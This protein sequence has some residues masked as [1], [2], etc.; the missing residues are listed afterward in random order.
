MVGRLEGTVA[1]EEVSYNCSY[2]VTIAAARVYA[3]TGAINCG[4]CSQ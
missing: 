4:D 1:A 2:I 3:C